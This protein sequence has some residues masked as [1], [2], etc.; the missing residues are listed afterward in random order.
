VNR[1]IQIVHSRAFSGREAEY[2]DWYVAT[3]IPEVLTVDGVAS[4]KFFG[5]TSTADC[6][7]ADFLCVYELKTDDLRAT[8]LAM[9]VASGDMTPSSAMDVA[10]THVELF[11]PVTA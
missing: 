10:E 1:Y 4:A 3:H 7:N 5:S 11:E 6:T 8:R 9:A 2:R